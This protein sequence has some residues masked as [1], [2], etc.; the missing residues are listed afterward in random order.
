M[1]DRDLIDQIAEIET[2]YDSE[3]VFSKFVKKYGENYS[4]EDFVKFLKERYETINKF[5]SPDR[6]KKD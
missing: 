6:D 1:I 5:N 3:I 4:R 2:E